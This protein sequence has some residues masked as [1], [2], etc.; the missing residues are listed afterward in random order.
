[1]GQVLL[2]RAAVP[3]GAAMCSCVAPLVVKARCEF[4][5]IHARC[6]SMNMIW[7]IHPELRLRARASLAGNGQH[8]KA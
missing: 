5:G 1:M 7:Q 2:K 4:D 8:A 3:F 6:Q